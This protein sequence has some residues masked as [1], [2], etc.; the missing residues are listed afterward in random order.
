MSNTEANLWGDPYARFMRTASRLVEM[1]DM[2][3][4]ADVRQMWTK[5]SERKIT[6][7]VVGGETQ[8]IRHFV[9]CWS[10]DADV[11]IVDSSY[12]PDAIQEAP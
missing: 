4:V 2:T 10:G 3:Q 6:L 9:R 5:F 1:L 7:H 8:K 11:V 12:R